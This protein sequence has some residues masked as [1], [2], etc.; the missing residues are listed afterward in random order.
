MSR[1][2]YREDLQPDEKPAHDT[3]SHISSEE[4]AQIEEWLAWELGR[5]LATFYAYGVVPGEDDE[6]SAAGLDMMRRLRNGDD[7]DPR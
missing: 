7:Q 5:R 1:Y 4:R 6:R 3:A 2:S